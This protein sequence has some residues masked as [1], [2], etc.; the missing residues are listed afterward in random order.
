MSPDIDPAALPAT[1]PPS[2]RPILVWII[3][4]F[5]VLA[6]GFSLFSLTLSH[7]MASDPDLNDRQRE[8]FASQTALDYV[9]AAGTILANMVG[10]IILFF[11]RRAAFYFFAG[12]FAVSILHTLYNIAVNDWLGVV[13]TSGLV[14]AAIGWGVNL[15]IVLYVWSL[16]RKGALR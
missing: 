4:I 1:R 7:A 13:G 10:A 2:R 9:L 14:I 16:F 6:T 15:A 8:F 3:S 11:M 12:S 5:C